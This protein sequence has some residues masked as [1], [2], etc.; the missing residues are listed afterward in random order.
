MIIDCI[1]D[2]HGFYPKLKGGD[3][4]IIGGDLTPFDKI[5]E[6]ADFFRWL[7]K[8]DYEKKVLIAGNHDVF[9]SKGWPQTKEEADTCAEIREMV[10]EGPQDFDYLCDSGC[11]FG[12]FKIWG[13][14]WSLW[15]HGINPKCKA[16]T[17]SEQDLANKYCKI[18][19]DTDILITHTPPFGILDECSKGRVGSNELRSLILS[20][21]R[22][23]KLKLHVFGHIHEMGGCMFESSLCKFVNAAIMDE[24]YDPVHEPR[25]IEL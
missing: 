5:H 3:L 18:P 21:R 9:I 4:L 13:S 24:N 11:E 8:Q 16:F 1:S 15:F 17:G 19:R 2:L 6:Y 25:M 10:G 14:P 7:K 20:R 23:P 22:M 12:G